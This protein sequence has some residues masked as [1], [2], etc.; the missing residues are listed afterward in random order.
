[1]LGSILQV[2]ST[3]IPYVNLYRIETWDRDL[4]TVGKN[5]LDLC[6]NDPFCVNKLGLTPGAVLED[7][8]AQIDSGTAYF[9]W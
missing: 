8:Y 6:G 9:V 7:I 3:Y 4:N 2:C 5:L 1:M